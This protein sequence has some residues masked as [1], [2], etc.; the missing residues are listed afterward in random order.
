MHVRCAYARGHVHR[1]RETPRKGI[2][3]AKA[4]KNPPGQPDPIQGLS[5]YCL[6]TRSLRFGSFLLSLRHYSFLPFPSFHLDSSHT[7][8]SIQ[9]STCLSQPLA[10]SSSPSLSSATKSCRPLW[11][12]SARKW[13]RAWQSMVTTWPWSQASS[14]V[15]RTEMRKGEISPGS[16]LCLT[17]LLTM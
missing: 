4:A 5:H 11:P 6:R 12:N 2:R 3:L 17:D 10:H 15:Y 1:T 7:Y 13:R 16:R 14:P 8:L 9:T